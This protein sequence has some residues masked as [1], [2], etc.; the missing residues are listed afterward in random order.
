MPGAPLVGEW[1]GQSA[2]LGASLG[3][4]GIQALILIRKGLQFIKIYFTRKLQPGVLKCQDTKLVSGGT[5][6]GD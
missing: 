6:S 3:S 4:P 2:P 1:K 5:T